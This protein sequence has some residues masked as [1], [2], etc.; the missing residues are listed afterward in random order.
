[1]QKGGQKPMD[2]IVSTTSVAAE[3]LNLGEKIGLIAPGMEADPIGVDG[4][5][6]EDITALRCM[7]FVVK[8]G[9]IYKNRKRRA[10]EEEVHA[11]AVY[12]NISIV[13]HSRSP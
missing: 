9:K 11:H 7:V 12:G 13:S 5:P 10:L 6:P 4:D 1:M 8:G 3:S 2:A